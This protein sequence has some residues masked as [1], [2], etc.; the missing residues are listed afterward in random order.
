[1]TKFS[2]AGQSDVRDR[3]EPVFFKDGNLRGCK[4]YLKT[5]LH[6]LVLI[7]A[8][9]WALSMPVV[10]GMIHPSRVQHVARRAD[11][12]KWEA[13]SIRP[14]K[15]PPGQRGGGVMLSAGRMAL[16]CQPVST[17]IAWAYIQYADG[18]N[19]PFYSVGQSGT[20]MEGGPSWLRSDRYTI[21]AKPEGTPGKAMMQGPMLQAILE[22]RF[23]LKFH[24]ERRE[25]SIYELTVTKSGS[26]LQRF[27]DG[28]CIPID[29]SKGCANIIPIT[30]RGTAE[31][32]DILPKFCSAG[33]PRPSDP[34]GIGGG[35]GPA[36]GAPDAALQSNGA[37]LG[38]VTIGV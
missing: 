22:D 2:E 23:N 29:A 33:P 36:A 1:L 11:T 12:P 8:A 15:V 7:V 25:I 27:T 31:S 13:V 10:N 4:T 38:L 20:A 34:R 14:C 37:T 32:T 3:H 24:W 6:Y 5:P 18:Q 30:P 26:K 16:N 35:T 9:T 21:N 17:F 19:H 28:T